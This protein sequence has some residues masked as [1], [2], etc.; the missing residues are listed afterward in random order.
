M[1]LK[2]NNHYVLYYYSS[3]L[4]I[5]DIKHHYNRIDLSRVEADIILASRMLI[6]LVN[7]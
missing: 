5:Y 1:T 7:S 4:H 2:I 6:N 3:T